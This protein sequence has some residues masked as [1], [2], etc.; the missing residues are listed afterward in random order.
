MSQVTATF[1]IT[2][3]SLMIVSGAINTIGTHSPT[4]PTSSRTSRWCTRE[5][6][7]STSS[8]PTCR[9]L[10]IHPGNHHVLRRGPCLRH[11]HLHEA[12]RPLDLQHAH[13]RRQV[14]G[15]GGPLQQ[16]TPGH[17]RHERS[18]NIY[19]A[20]CSLKLC[21]WVCLSDD[22]RWCHCDYLPIFYRLPQDEGT[23][24]SSGWQRPCTS[25]SLHRWCLQSYLLLFQ[26]L[27]H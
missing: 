2:I 22:A 1:R 16:T 20:V 7:T 12:P 3:I 25:G 21:G 24:Q 15:Q 6:S 11:L 26:L 19:P 23:T 10:T 27:R 9:Y 8:T 18:R 5:S 14:A 4:Q 17:P 13:A